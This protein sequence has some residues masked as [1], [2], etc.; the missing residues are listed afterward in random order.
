MR[1]FL[2]NPF[3]PTQ[4]TQPK[5]RKTR[6]FSGF[7][8][9]FYHFY[10]TQPKTRKKPVKPGFFAGFRL[11]LGYDLETRVF[12][13]PEQYTVVSNGKPWR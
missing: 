8:S 4:L 1:N 13:N 3:N 2:I 7:L 5:T 12:T 10:L 11:G 6:V 9:L